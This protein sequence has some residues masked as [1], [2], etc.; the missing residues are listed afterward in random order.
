MYYNTTNESGETLKHYKEVSRTQEQFILDI[1]NSARD[2]NKELIVGISRLS[3]LVGFKNTPITSIRRAVN[4]LINSGDL[5]YT[6][7]K[8]MGMYGRKESVIKLK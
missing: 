2:G 6:G 5:I 3:T 8:V 7:D 4:S 1:F